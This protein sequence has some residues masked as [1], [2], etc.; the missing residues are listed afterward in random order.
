MLKKLKDPKPQFFVVWTSVYGTDNLDMAQEGASILR[1]P[2]VKNYYEAK[3]KV[4]MDFGK[5]VELPRDAPLAY[6]VY[7]L[8]DGKTEWKNT[9]PKPHEWWHQ[10]IDGPKFL[11][12]NDLK[13]GIEKL[14]KAKP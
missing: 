3:P 5:L 7:F 8:Y 9:P 12:A 6:D 13:I 4:V 10:V 2:R 14:L 11:D 1:D